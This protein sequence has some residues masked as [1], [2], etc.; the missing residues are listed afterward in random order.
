MN[1][2]VFELVSS[3]LRE[4]VRSPTYHWDNAKRVGLG[5]IVQFTWRGEGRLRRGGSVLSCAV[6]QA[7]LMLEGT[8]TEY[9]YPAELDRP[10]EFSW[11]N[12]LGARPV[13]A[14]LIQA[15]GDV[16]TLDAG[17]ETAGELM[18]I[19]RLY[20]SKGFRDRYHTSEALSRLVCALARELS[21]VRA[22]GESPVRQ[23]E[24]YLRDHH[25]RP[26]N[27]KEVAAGFSMSREHFSRIFHA[28]T[29]V[30]PAHYLRDLRLRTA[31][32]LLCGTGMPI[33][34]VAVNSGFGSATHFCRAFRWAFG[35]SP[36]TVRSTNFRA[37]PM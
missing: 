22:E 13:I 5:V 34:E 24:N 11:V 18:S 10:W 31:R 1:D 23:A 28:E 27:I 29:G 30:T 8:P 32:Q 36:G 33:Q 25:R 2:V 16:V 17:G 26:I 6:G 4:S 3:A 37:A 9:Y 7:L 14:D 35:E 21:R 19:A 15:Y 20:E 12:F